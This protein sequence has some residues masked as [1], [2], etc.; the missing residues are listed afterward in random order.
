MVYRNK[1]KK[2]NKSLKKDDVE[3]IVDQKL[4]RQVETKIIKH[5][6]YVS[7]AGALNT[8]AFNNNV[9]LL[10]PNATYMNILQGNGQSNRIGNKVH[11]YKYNFKFMLSTLPYNATTNSV[12]MP[13]FVMMYIFALKQSNQSLANAQGACQSGAGGQF[14]QNNAS[15]QGFTG[16]IIDWLSDVNKDSIT[17]YKK[18]KYRLGAAVYSSNTGS[19]ANSYNFANNDFPLI[20]MD[21]LDLTKYMPKS[22]HY[23]DTTATTNARH[24]YVV[25]SPVPHDGNAWT[26]TTVAVPSVL[27][28]QMTYQYKD[29]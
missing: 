8:G 3:K 10:T 18:K 29:A 11:T 1:S 2:G 16:N 5:Q 19:Q 15:S 13:Q 20:A 28:Y 26:D 21:S 23:D 14:F 7:L 17:I 9:L 24:V 4:N 6:S 25:F 12:P 22:L 27:D